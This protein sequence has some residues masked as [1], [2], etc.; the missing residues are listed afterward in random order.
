MLV[1]YIFSFTIIYLLYRWGWYRSLHQKKN[2]NTYR[3][4]QIS[5]IIPFRNEIEHLN[6]LKKSILKLSFSPLEF[7]WVNDHSE[8]DSL[9][10]LSNLPVNHTIISLSKE[11]KGKKTA[12]RRGIDISKGSY[13]LTW[14]ADITVPTDYFKAI[15]NQHIT[16]L[17]IL[18]VRM[19]GRNIVEKLYELDYYFLN[20]VNRSVS[21]FTYP[22][23]ASGANLL[24]HKSTFSTIDSY[25]KHKNIASGDDQFLLDDFK[26]NNKQIQLISE[27]DL[28][29]ETH[30][31]QTLHSF[32][33][34]RLRWITKS[35][36]IKDA[37]TNLINIIGVS[38]L[39]GFLFLLIN[40]NWFL[41]IGFKIV[42]DILIFKPYLRSIER[43]SLIYISPFFSLLYPFY[44]LTI[45]IGMLFLTNPKWK[46]RK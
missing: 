18:P 41:I 3:I 25:N 28:I 22:F 21:G 45:A 15:Q 27:S 4:E 7:I 42:V 10:I 5:V 19:K 17:S 38:Y 20:C 30:T 35:T 9:D 11:D 43:K 29:V 14:D 46:G 12:I 31:P 24:F 26:K 33:L 23:V 37:L 39:L 44:F 8:D 6:N 13:I 16:D 32:Y 34:Q 1:A 36:K 40:H 2:S